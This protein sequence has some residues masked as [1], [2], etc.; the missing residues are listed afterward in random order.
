MVR[1][2]DILT[3][4]KHEKSE[5]QEL[6]VELLQMNVQCAIPLLI[7]QS[8]KIITASY[9]GFLYS[10]SCSP[11]IRDKKKDRRRIPQKLKCVS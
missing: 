3:G 6:I 2:N 10:T 7:L 4:S 8:L 1:Y 11:L 9:K 5:E